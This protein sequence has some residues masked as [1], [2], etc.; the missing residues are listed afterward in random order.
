VNGIQAQHGSQQR[1]DN[2]NEKLETKQKNTLTRELSNIKEA[3]TLLDRK[4][5]KINNQILS[6]NQPA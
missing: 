6:Q 3:L 5:D 4:K 1:N 2:Q